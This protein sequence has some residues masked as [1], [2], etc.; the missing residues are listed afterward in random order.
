[1]YEPIDEP[2]AASPKAGIATCNACKRK[3]PQKYAPSMQGNKHQVAL[4]Q[5]TTSLGTSNASIALA[6][7]SDKLINKRIHQCADIV[8][9]VMAQVSL[10]AALKKWGK[11]AEESVGKEMKQ[12]YWQN[13]FKPMPW[14]SPTAKQQKKVLGS[15]I[16]VERKCDGVLKA[17]QVAGGNKQQGY[18]TKEYTSSPTVSLEAVLL[19]CIVDENKNRD[20]AIVDTQMHLS[21]LL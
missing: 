21:R 3:Q 9:M 12:L 15:P 20:V 18:I 8:G 10:K 19:V 14:K 5:I 13:S 6:K 11:E 2:K 4:A 1:M 17:W 7:M 16:F